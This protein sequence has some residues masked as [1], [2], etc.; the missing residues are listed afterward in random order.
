MIEIKARYD[1]LISSP[2]RD[3]RGVEVRRVEHHHFV[4]GHLGDA[5]SGGFYINKVGV[6]PDEIVLKVPDIKKVD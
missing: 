3:E 2:I 1:S 6:I 5:I 4:F